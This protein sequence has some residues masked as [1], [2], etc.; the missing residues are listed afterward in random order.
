M[1]LL[2]L[3]AA[4]AAEVTGTLSFRASEASTRLVRLGVVALVRY[5]TM[6]GTVLYCLR[7][8]SRRP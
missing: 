5:L 6:Q 3:A 2:I 8:R 4:V 7:A 1:A